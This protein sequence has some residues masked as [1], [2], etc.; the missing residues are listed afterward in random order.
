[1]SDEVTET[2]ASSGPPWQSVGRN[3]RRVLGVLV[4]K[5]KTTPE[6]Y[7]LTLNALTN[8]CNQKNNRFPKLDLEPVDVQNAIEK[9]SDL[10]AVTELGSGR[11]E[12]FRH[13]LTDWLGVSSVELAVMAELLMRGAQSIGDLRGR[14][15]R[16]SSIASVA[17]LR[18]IVQSLI[19]R[20]LIVPLT[21]PGRGQVVTHNL[22]ADPEELSDLRREFNGGVIVEV[23]KSKLAAALP[24]PTASAEDNPSSHSPSPASSSSLNPENSSTSTAAHSVQASIETPRVVPAL[25][26]ASINSDPPSDEV[27]ELK[28]EVADLKAEVARIRSEIDD[29]WSNIK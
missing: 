10:G 24:T 18:P 5:A 17:E 27:T 21:D 4:E 3:E 14:A 13:H 8:G 2:E 26:P 23:D 29:L 9:L 12:K 19:L 22:Y 11:V 1:M 7:P 15:N 20:D 25:P 6:A 28:K 16:M